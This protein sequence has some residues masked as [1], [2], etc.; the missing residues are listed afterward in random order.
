M[1][2]GGLIKGKILNNKVGT[3]G[4]NLSGSAQGS[5]IL[6]E[7]NGTG[8]GGTYNVLISGNTLRQCFDKGIDLLGGRDG[9][10]NL[11]AT[12]TN[13]DVNELT[14]VASRWAIRLETGSSLTTETA[15]VCADIANNTLFAQT[16]GDEMSIR[17]RSNVTVRLPGYT[18]AANDDAAVVTYLQNRN[19]AGGTATVSHTLATNVQN[20]VP[21]GSQ[22]TQP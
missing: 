11:N 6:A 2:S 17:Q 20:S 13:N 7:T 18:G 9:N 19:L 4:S 8:A 5:C 22:C 1:A 12:V 15:T 21:A 14:N 10:H 16:Q 3:S